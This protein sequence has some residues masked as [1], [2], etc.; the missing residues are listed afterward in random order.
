M[1]GYALAPS[2]E[3]SSNTSDGKEGYLKR[4]SQYY[5]IGGLV[6]GLIDLA[7][8][9]ETLRMVEL[10]A[11]YTLALKLEEDAIFHLPIEYQ[12]KINP[13]FNNST[14]F[15][16]L[17]P[18][19]QSRE[20]SHSSI[21]ANTHQEQL[22]RNP[23]YLYSANQLMNSSKS[24]V[25]TNS[26]IQRLNG[27]PISATELTRLRSLL[28]KNYLVEAKCG[29]IPQQ[30]KIKVNDEFVLCGYPNTKYTPGEYNLTV[31]EL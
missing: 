21:L 24:A 7:A 10:K 12:Q 2:Q 25:A 6:G 3:F 19:V 30:V 1:L 23:L 8:G 9:E 13:G 20:I 29:T 5:A 11:G 27:Q 18:P 17:T 4:P 14:S 28:T 26:S 31:D 22:N 16:T 15:S